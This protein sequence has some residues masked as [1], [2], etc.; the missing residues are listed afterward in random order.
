MKIKFIILISISFLICTKVFCQ[1]CDCDIY[2]ITQVCKDTCGI[3][4]LQTGTKAQLKKKLNLDDET[5]QQIVNLKSR[6]N[7]KT[8]ASFQNVLTYK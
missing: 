3:K 5:A 8:I 1:K 7:R 4:L 2:P 6:K